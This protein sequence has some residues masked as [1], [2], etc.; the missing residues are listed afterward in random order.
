MISR[1]DTTF[2]LPP[3]RPPDTPLD[4]FMTYLLAEFVFRQTYVVEAFLDARILRKKPNFLFAVKNADS[5][6]IFYATVV[7]L[8]ENDKLEQIINSNFFQLRTR[9]FF[10]PQAIECTIP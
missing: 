6:V 4:L 9:D 8:P 3:P 2:S 7:N 1:E 10:Q 5:A